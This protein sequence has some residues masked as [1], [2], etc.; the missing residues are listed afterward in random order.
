MIEYKE[1]C[2]ALRKTEKTKKCVALTK[3]ECEDC[4]FYK[5]YEQHIK[6]LMQYPWDESK[7][8]TTSKEIYK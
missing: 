2:F 6:D 5:S 8:R 7:R 3:L 4:N 1:D